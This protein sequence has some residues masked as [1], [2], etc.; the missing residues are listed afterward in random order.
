[1]KLDNNRDHVVT[2]LD[3]SFYNRDNCLCFVVVVLWNMHDQEKIVF[4]D[5][6]PIQS[7]LHSD[8]AEYVNRNCPVIITKIGNDIHVK[9]LTVKDLNT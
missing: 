1:M 6:W 9:V 7:R 8:L 2:D 3:L 4:T 5:F